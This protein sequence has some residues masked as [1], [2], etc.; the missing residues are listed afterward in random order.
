MQENIKTQEQALQ[1]VTRIGELLGGKKDISSLE[2]VT[3]L[4]EALSIY[5][6]DQSA[7]RQDMQRPGNM[8]MGIAEMSTK[9]TETALK[10]SPTYPPISVVAMRGLSIDIA[11]AAHALIKW[12]DS[13]APRKATTHKKD[14]PSGHV[15]NKPSC[16]GD[17]GFDYDCYT[18]DMVDDCFPYTNNLQKP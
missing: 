12:C 14:K 9:L 6:K 10:Y 16:F 2:E 5:A 8:V 11:A 7:K 4:T 13:K 17:F 15:Y 18:C 3:K 1:A